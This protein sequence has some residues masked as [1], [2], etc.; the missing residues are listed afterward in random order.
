MDRILV[1]DRSDSSGSY[2]GSEK[3]TRVAEM[4]HSTG[5]CILGIAGDTPDKEGAA[6]SILNIPYFA[7]NQSDRVLY[8]TDRA[9]R[10][11]CR[12]GAP[13]RLRRERVEAECPTGYFA[14]DEFEA[15]CERDV[16]PPGRGT[17]TVWIRVF[18][19]IRAGGIPDAE[20]VRRTCELEGA[21][22]TSPARYRAS[23]SCRRSY[24]LPSYEEAPRAPDGSCPSGFTLATFEETN[25]VPIGSEPSFDISEYP[26]GSVYARDWC[27]LQPEIDTLIRELREPGAP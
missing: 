2:G 12:R 6:A 27:Q 21:R 24:G 10:T 23:L 18:M 14:D 26:E 20:Q 4:L 3:A 13:D 25:Q 15:K 8:R 5:A 7:V 17:E 9:A 1:L 16:P 19:M 22:V 11:A